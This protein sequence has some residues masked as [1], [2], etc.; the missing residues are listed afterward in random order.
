VPPP[1]VPFTRTLAVGCSDAVDVI[2]VKRA[3]SRA[4]FWQWQEFDDKYSASFASLGVK[5]FQAAKRLAADG[6]YGKA[7]HD[8]L[9][10]TRREG[11]AAEWAF[12][13]TAI[14]LMRQY[15]SA[16]QKAR[17]ML[18]FA[19][20]FDG[21][22]GYGA[23]HDMT[24]KDDDIH[25]AFDCSSS[26]S[27]LLWKFNLLGSSHA[28]VSD[29]FERWGLMGRGKYITIHA[30]DDHV[31][32]EFTLPEGYFRFDTSPHGDGE[33]G[34]RVR[35]RVRSDRGFVHRHAKGT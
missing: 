7:T 16:L 26:T 14:S 2:G 10:A 18:A 23:E 22:Y 29:W 20:G 3:I 21:P 34:P 30:N 15:D 12:D 5:K 4:G 19:R 33:R 6:V 17:A 9:R 25:D 24:F 35:T 32:V 11:H 27:F 8:K 28:Q 31:W 1:S 13:D